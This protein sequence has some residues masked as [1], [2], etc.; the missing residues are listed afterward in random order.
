MP[1]G[2]PIDQMSTPNTTSPR[3]GTRDVEAA[4]GIGAG[5]HL[6]AA[7]AVRWLLLALAAAAAIGATA[8]WWLG[9]PQPGISY[10]TAPAARG[11]LTVTVTA[12]GYAQPTNKIDIST[13]LSGTVHSVLVDYNTPVAAGQVLAELDTERLEATVAMSRARLIAARAR[14]N[15][16]EATIEERA[17]DY[18]RQQALFERGVVSTQDLALARA[19]YDRA[20]AALASAR[21]DVQLAQAELAVNETDLS[22]ACICS[23]I[24]DE[25]DVG[26]TRAGQQA[27]FTV[28]AYPGRRFPA[29]VRD[30]RYAPETVQGV[31]T[32]KALLTI[33]NSE[34]LLRPG[35]TATAE[36]V[37][38]ELKD[39]LLVPNAALRFSPPSDRD[40]APAGSHFQRLMP[41]PP[42]SRPATRPAEKDSERE[43]WVLREGVAVAVPVVVGASDGRSTEIVRGDLSDAEQVIVDSSTASR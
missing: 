36:I 3:V 13:E 9:G 35:M 20:V 42:R 4:L 10:V 30:I 33:D 22:K 15:E 39:A 1:T 34:Q 25:A 2:T 37:V 32:Y 40:A 19:A 28:D 23:P 17:G 7:P 21:A 41:G 27:T 5:R 24:D 43:I 38:Q 31:V 16:A 6:S 26:S 14:V 11:M 18:E 12:T 29:E 8:Y